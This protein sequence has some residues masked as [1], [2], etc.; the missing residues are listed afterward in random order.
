MNKT[1]Q[2]TPKQLRDEAA[3]KVETLQLQA[4][5]ATLQHA[6]TLI[7]SPQ[8]VV[9]PWSD[10]PQFDTF[11]QWPTAFDRPYLWSDIDDRTEGRYRPLYET[12]TDLKVIRAHGRRLKALFPVAEGALESLTNYVVKGLSFSV[13]PKNDRA[14]TVPGIEQM[15]AAVQ[16][17]VDRFLEHNEFIDSLDREIHDNS[18]EDG[19]VFCT[20]YLDEKDVRLELVEPEYILQPAH[21]EALERMLDCGYRLNLWWHGVHTQWNKQ[22]KRDD[23]ARPLG[24]HAVFDK[25]GEQ[26]DYLPISRVEH[27]KRN[28]GRTGRR[29]VSDFF[30]VLRDLEQEA[31]IRRNTAEGA[32]I[33]AAIVMIRQHAEGV[34]KSTIEN[35]VSTNSTSNYQRYTQDSSRTTYAE[36]VRPGTVKD[37]PY[38]MQATLGPM[39]TLKSDVYVQVCQFLL[40]TI[41]QRWNAPEY[42]S[43]DA[44]NA[45]YSS[46]LVAESPFV[47][48]REA[49]QSFY[50]QAF[51]RLLW[52]A[53]A[54][55]HR[56]GHMSSWS[57]EQIRALVAIVPEFASPA[58]RD[59]KMQADTDKVLHELKVK[60]K[61]TIAAENDLDYDEEQQNMADEPKQEPPASPFGNPFGG[62]PFGPPKPPQFEQQH[63]MA[64]RAAALLEALA[65]RVAPLR[66]D[67]GK[68]ITI[69]GNPVKISDDGTVLTGPMK[70]TKLGGGGDSSGGAAEKSTG[71]VPKADP[72]PKS[73]GVLKKKSKDGKH[74]WEMSEDEY[75]QAI[76][77]GA[78]VDYQYDKSRTVMWGVSS[79]GQKFTGR[80]GKT[81]QVTKRGS[82][83][84]L[85]REGAKSGD[86]S[87][88]YVEKEGK[89]TFLAVDPKYRGR[90][91]GEELQYRYRLA[92]PFNQSGGFSE[93][94]EKGARKIYRR[95]MASVKATVKESQDSEP[96]LIPDDDPDG[97]LIIADDDAGEE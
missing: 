75:I 38:G 55:Y 43:G 70:G 66:E 29:G 41:W 15:Q 53:L 23:V 18:R 76:S 82:S 68:W 36:N 14:K 51:T 72:L 52:K 10:Y 33:L 39:G 26:W 45:N 95:I 87:I 30:I 97:V 37:I 6:L 77:G 79:K 44:S 11:N 94:G 61:R 24:Y 91:L 71:D 25:L 22:L 8:P 69:K 63:P 96:P 93:A 32:A 73:A 67:K 5:A 80:D 28:V 56:A 20:L 86:K 49:D 35:M 2:P 40:R 34:T 7:E 60:S 13:Q 16:A 78:K 88:G 64:G 4:E 89:S 21:S 58:S 31:K 3:A 57:W 12:A 81:Y 19:E 9:V 48:A 85:F 74:I 90:G 17:V 83:L 42:M 62:S 47:R 84:F 92:N 1:K 54:I 65:E 46:T 27:I 59:R 50:G